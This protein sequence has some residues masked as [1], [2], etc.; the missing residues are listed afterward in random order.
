MILADYL[1]SLRVAIDASP[2]E[3]AAYLGINPEDWQRWESGDLAG[4]S[5]GVLGWIDWRTTVALALWLHAHQPPT[6]PCPIMLAGFG[7]FAEHLESCPRCLAWS[8]RAQRWSVSH[9]IA[10]T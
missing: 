7:A 2:E 6:S 10:I 5:V 1:R 9:A 3:F 8:Y 4:L